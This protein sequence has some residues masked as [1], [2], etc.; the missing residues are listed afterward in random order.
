MQIGDIVWALDGTEMKVKPAILHEINNMEW[1]RIIFFDSSETLWY[2]LREIATSKK[3]VTDK[4][5][6]SR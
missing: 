1:H 6:Y 5:V 4:Y 3:E 2:N